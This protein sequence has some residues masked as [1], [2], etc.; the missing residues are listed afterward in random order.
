MRARKFDGSWSFSFDPF[1]FFAAVAIATLGL[2]FLACWVFAFLLFFDAP[3]PLFSRV[4]RRNLAFRQTA[5]A[6]GDTW[7]AGSLFR[8][9]EMHFEYRGQ[10]FQLDGDRDGY[11]RYMR[12]T[13]LCPPACQ[14][15]RCE[16]TSFKVIPPWAGCVSPRSQRVHRTF[17]QYSAFAG[18]IQP[19]SPDR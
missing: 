12:L 17:R 11:F 5:E 19:A 18:M 3:D 4:R 6:L 14:A 1:G 7:I 13:A 15:L 10:P 2:V 9:P 8:L 16:I